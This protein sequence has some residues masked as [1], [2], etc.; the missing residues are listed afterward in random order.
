VSI[1]SASGSINKLITESTDK[2]TQ[3]HRAWTLPGRSRRPL[4]I[5]VVVHEACS[6]PFNLHIPTWPARAP[7]DTATTVFISRLV[8]SSTTKQCRDRRMFLHACMPWWRS[9]PAG[10]RANGGPLMMNCFAVDD[11]DRSITS[12]LA[13]RAGPGRARAMDKAMRVRSRLQSI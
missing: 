6:C 10:E 5:P 3:I 9:R 11:L 2:S 7:V 8:S 4:F 1:A 13:P 12:Y